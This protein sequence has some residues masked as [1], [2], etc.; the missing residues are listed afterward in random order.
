MLNC[1]TATNRQK[2][3]REKTRRRCRTKLTHFFIF[4]FNALLRVL[5][6]FLQNKLAEFIGWLIY[7]IAPGRRRLM[8][9][10]LKRAFKEE[11][12]DSELE[13]IALRSIQNTIKS[14][15]EF[16]RFPLYSEADIIRIVEV[17][18]AENI[19]NARKAGKGVIFATAHFGNWELLAARIH[20]L[21]H[22]MTAVG[23]PQEDGVVNEMIVNLRTSKGTRNIPRGVPMYEHITCLLA[24]NETVGLVSDQNA[25]VKGLFV[26]FFG[27]KVSAFK[28]PGLFAVRTGCK[29]IPLFI[30]REGYEK[31]RGIFLPAVEIRP[32][33]DAGKDV[34]A[35]CKGY[36]KSIEDFVRKYPDHWFWIHKRWKTPPPGG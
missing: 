18:G 28:G 32:S 2:H 19:E 35:Y 33:G 20:T 14:A 34:L 5:P 8:V 15:F 21:G 1:C 16:M 36:T 31:H 17:E 7:I 6:V 26:D 24:A 10:N 3:R 12:A 22:P 9:S 29:I 27:S 13:R 25:G 23:R 11:Y 4:L 30:I